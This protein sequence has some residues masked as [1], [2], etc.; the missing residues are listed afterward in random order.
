M[1]VKVCPQHGSS[2]FCMEQNWTVSSHFLM[3]ELI[4]IIPAVGTVHAVPRKLA[5]SSFYAPQEGSWT[6][7]WTTR[8]PAACAPW[9]ACWSTWPPASGWTAS[10]AWPL[11]PPW[12]PQH[13]SSCG[14]TLC[15]PVSIQLTRMLIRAALA[16]FSPNVSYHGSKRKGVL[17]R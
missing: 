6:P 9:A 1:F 2:S 4:C 11:L 10:G 8:A 5:M 7:C 16:Y 13:R 12:R 15:W 17:S 3:R 14:R